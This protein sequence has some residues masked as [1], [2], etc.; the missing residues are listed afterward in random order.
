MERGNKKNK[1]NLIALQNKIK[2]K[3]NHYSSSL[4]LLYLRSSIFSMLVM[5]IADYEHHLE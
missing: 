4:F 1:L 5:Y 3:I 2:T